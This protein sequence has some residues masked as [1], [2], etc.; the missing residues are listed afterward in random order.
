MARDSHDQHI[1]AALVITKQA[2]DFMHRCIKGT[3]VYCVLYGARQFFRSSRFRKILFPTLA[4][5]LL[6]GYK[7]PEYKILNPEVFVI[8]TDPQH[9]R[10]GLA[11]GLIGRGEAWLCQNR[12]DVFHARTGAM[13]EN[14]AIQFYLNMGFHVLERLDGP[15]K[16]FLV[17]KKKL[18]SLVS[19]VETGA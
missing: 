12:I 11:A 1:V 14:S 9:Q 3:F 8:F 6:P 13:P 16:S 5:F 18:G 17:F 4:S 2:E 15:F 10:T 19:G 7:L